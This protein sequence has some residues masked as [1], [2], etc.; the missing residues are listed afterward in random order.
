MDGFD[1]SEMSILRSFECRPIALGD[2]ISLDRTSNIGA[3][4]SDKELVSDI[5][6][7]SSFSHVVSLSC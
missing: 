6:A 2:L 1:Y 4:F 7:F 3:E 5:D